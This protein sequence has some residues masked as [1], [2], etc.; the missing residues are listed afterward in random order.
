MKNIISAVLLVLLAL[1][2]SGY[3]GIVI[4]VAHGGQN[5]YQD[6]SITTDDAGNKIINCAQPGYSSCP[7]LTAPEPKSQMYQHES[8][9][10]RALI[11]IAAASIKNGLLSGRMVSANGTCLC[12][13][14]VA[15]KNDLS[16]FQIKISDLK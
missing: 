4:N 15:D 11:Q 3:S 6:V 14:I 12:E 1:P 7:Y 5:G 2:F 8:E 9:E 10:Y 13:W 16:T